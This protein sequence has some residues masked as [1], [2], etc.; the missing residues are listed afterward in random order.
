MELVFLQIQVNNHINKLY[1]E[2]ENL[3]L[4]MFICYIFLVHCATISASSLFKVVG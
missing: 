1:S 4:L 2:P 3:Y